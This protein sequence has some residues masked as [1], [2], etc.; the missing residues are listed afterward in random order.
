MAEQ[1]KVGDLVRRDNEDIWRVISV[2]EN[3]APFKDR[4]RCICERPPL[5]WLRPDG[6]RSRSWAKVGDEDSFT[7]A[8]LALLPGDALSAAERASEP[9]PLVFPMTNRMPFRGPAAE[10]EDEQDFPSIAHGDDSGCA[11]TRRMK[12]EQSRGPTIA[13]E[14]KLL[15]AAT[16]EIPMLKMAVYQ[17]AAGDF[18]AV[19]SSPADGHGATDFIR[20]SVIEV[21]EDNVQAAHFLVLDHFD[22]DRQ[23]QAMLTQI[24]WSLQREVA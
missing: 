24:G 9:A 3:Y 17:T 21:E 6:S 14:G 18:V 8:D 13:F 11:E 16:A 2:P 10:A 15:C 5:G 12:I 4:A 22:W 23:A 19:S 1:L 7:I 20:A